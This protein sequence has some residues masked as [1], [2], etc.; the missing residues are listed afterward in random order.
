[1]KST[2]NHL[3]FQKHFKEYSRQ[4][5]PVAAITELSCD[6]CTRKFRYTKA[7]NHHVKKA[8]SGQKKDEHPA[9]KDQNNKEQVGE[10]LKCDLCQRR[11]GSEWHLAP[12]RHNCP[13]VKANVSQSALVL[14]FIMLF[15]D[16]WW[17]YLT[18]IMLRKVWGDLQRKRRRSLAISVG[19]SWSAL[20]III[21]FAMSWF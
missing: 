15:G 11:V 16:K 1:M 9:A 4:I 8:H 3:I 6:Q 7:L 10:K 20:Y 5:S 2:W 12:S 18:F 19:R 21:S 14:T 13:G 17:Q